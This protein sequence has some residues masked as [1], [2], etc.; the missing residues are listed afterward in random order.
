MGGSNESSCLRWSLKADWT[1]E[2]NANG[3]TVDE[4][5]LGLL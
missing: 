1:M 2:R 4:K 5:I 3:F